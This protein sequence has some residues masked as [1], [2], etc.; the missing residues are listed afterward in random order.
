MR[1]KSAKVLEMEE[2]EKIEKKGVKT[3]KTKVSPVN[4]GRKSLG[5]G[6]SD[7]GADMPAIEAELAAMQEAPPLLPATAVKE[8]C[9]SSKG[10][11]LMAASVHMT[12]MPPS[13]A[14]L[15]ALKQAAKPIKVV[16]PVKTPGMSYSIVK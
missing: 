14:E 13:K 6:S 2:F 5:D 10:K 7:D 4:K 1:K 8:T 16:K 12:E 15:A 11:A 9:V 3:L